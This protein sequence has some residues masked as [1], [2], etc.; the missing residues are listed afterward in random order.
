MSSFAWKPTHGPATPLP[1]WGL[2]PW[3]MCV[4]MPGLRNNPVP[5]GC[6]TSVQGTRKLC[7]TTRLLVGFG[8]LAGYVVM[9]KMKEKTVSLPPRGP[10]QDGDL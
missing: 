2:T 8:G 5:R 1:R 7:E 10:G 9:A 4:A 6:T 3:R